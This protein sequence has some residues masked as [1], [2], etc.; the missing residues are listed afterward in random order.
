MKAL[1]DG[2]S[3]LHAA[4]GVVGLLVFWL[5][6]VFRKGGVDHRRYGQIFAKAMYAA[7]FT[8]L[9]MATSWLVAPW[10]FRPSLASVAAEDLPARLQQLRLMGYFLAML[11][12]LLI[13]NVRHGVLVLRARDDRALLRRPGHVALLLLLIATGAGAL[14]LGFAYQRLLLQ[15][16]SVV[17][18]GNGI[19]MLV[20][21]FKARLTRMEWWTEH[22]GNLLGAGVAAH[23]AFLVFGA[24]RFMS[25]WIPA[26]YQILP[27]ILPS[28]IGVPAA[29]WTTRYYRRKFN[30]EVVASATLS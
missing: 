21:S 26:G 24:N 18:L 29:L 25:D 23:T 1:Y 19:G 7:G 22:A 30:P 9:L 17:V 12:L 14:W 16:F 11:G 6:V 2:V 5:P 27:W 4:A 3:F 10:T 13:T 28:L 20:Y 8:G 15:I